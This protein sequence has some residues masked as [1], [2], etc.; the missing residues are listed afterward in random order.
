MGGSVAAGYDLPRSLHTC[1]KLSAGDAFNCT[2]GVFMENHQSSYGV[3]SR[4]L[5]D[6]ACYQGASI[7]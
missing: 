3:R 4:W 5:K 1:D 6:N 7:E 2:G